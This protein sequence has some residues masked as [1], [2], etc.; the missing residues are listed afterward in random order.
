MTYPFVLDKAPISILIRV[1]FPAP[2]YPNR[3]TI[4]PFFICIDT[5]LN[6][7]TLFEYVFCKLV[8]LTIGDYY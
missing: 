3:P 4:Y 2:F 1:D 8:I 6:A 7:N 5:P